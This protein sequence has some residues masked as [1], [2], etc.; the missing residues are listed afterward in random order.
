M[1]KTIVIIGWHIYDELTEKEKEEFVRY[2][3]YKY[4]YE[5]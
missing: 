4:L 5:L 2:E 3:R 1:N